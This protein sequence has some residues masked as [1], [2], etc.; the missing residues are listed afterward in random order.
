MNFKY[1]HWESHELKEKSKKPSVKELAGALFENE[2]QAYRF[3]RTLCIVKQKGSV[4]LKQMPPDLP[5]ATWYRYLEMGYE[6]G[7]FD[8]KDDVYVKINRFTNPIKNFGEY[9]E[10]WLSKEETENEGELGVL[11]TRA[12]KGKYSG[13][14]TEKEG[15]PFEENT[16]IN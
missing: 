7:F 3:A 11:F 15:K 12:V 8:K 2:T 10:K 4:K 6:M 16:A 5:K 1:W 9:Y 14:E 13:K